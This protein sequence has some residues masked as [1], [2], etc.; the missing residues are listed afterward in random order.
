M[1]DLAMSDGGMADMAS[2]PCLNGFRLGPKAFGLVVVHS[3]RLAQG[4]WTLPATV[5]NSAPTVAK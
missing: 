1:P 3:A 2:P 5:T 4:F